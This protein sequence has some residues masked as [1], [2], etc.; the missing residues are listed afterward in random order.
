MVKN[1]KTEL[2]LE[3]PKNITAKLEGMTVTIKGPKGTVVK[4]YD[5][6]RDFEITLVDNVFY[7]KS[8]FARK[9]TVAKMGTI[10]SLINNVFVGV[11]K[12]YIYKMIIGYSHFPI[13]C[14]PPKTQN[15]DDEIKIMNFLGEREPRFV[16]TS[17]PN[18]KVDANK[19]EVVVSGIDKEAVSQTCASI[20][21]K[22]HIPHKD[23]RVF[24]DGIYVYSKG[25]QTGEVFWNIK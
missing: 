25:L 24:Q 13:T 16:Y 9:L 12:G 14:E 7:F 19:E 11:T 2:T 3:V 20:Q 10:R 17:G 18:V 5:H 22:C 23:Y 6:I 8:Y 21:K 4:N 1:F 15:G